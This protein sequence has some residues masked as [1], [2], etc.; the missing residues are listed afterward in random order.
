[1]TFF[2]SPLVGALAG[3]TSILL[4][5]VTNAG[6]VLDL[7]EGARYQDYMRLTDSHYALGL[8]VLLCFSERFFD[9]V[10][11]KL[12]ESASPAKA[13][14][15]PEAGGGKRT[16]KVPMIKAVLIGT[17]DNKVFCNFLSGHAFPL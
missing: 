6:M 12:D 5:I 16:D 11:S 7:S 14:N 17:E 4:T 13:S 15:G 8:A 3:W 9:R 1:M 10:V 2:I